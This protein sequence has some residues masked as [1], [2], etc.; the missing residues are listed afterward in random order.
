MKKAIQKLVVAGMIAGTILFVSQSFAEK[1]SSIKDKVRSGLENAP[2]GQAG[3]MAFVYDST[4]EWQK[5]KKNSEKKIEKNEKR[6]AELNESI[7]KETSD[8][9]VKMQTSVNELKDKNEDLKKQL[10]AYKDDGKDSFDAFKKKF[11]DEMDSITK[12]LK[13]IKIG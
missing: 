3:L 12:S 6:I 13:A 5:F 1:P 8:Q 2:V 7:G 9:K 10:S 11:D 4:S